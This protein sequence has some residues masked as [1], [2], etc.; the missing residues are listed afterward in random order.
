MEQQKPHV[1]WIHTRASLCSARRHTLPTTTIYWRLQALFFFFFAFTTPT[2][3]LTCGGAGV[4]AG[5]PSAVSTP[6]TLIGS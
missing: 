3:S 6:G 4:K 1:T 2:A 5:R